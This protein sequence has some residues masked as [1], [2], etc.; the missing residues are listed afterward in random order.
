MQAFLRK[1]AVR[2]AVTLVFVVIAWTM[3]SSFTTLK[4]WQQL[5]ASIPVIIVTQIIWGILHA[6]HKGLDRIMPFSRNTYARIFVQI[7][8]GL[9]LVWVFRSIGLYV[10]PRA[11]H[12][13]LSA[14]ARAT[15]ATITNLVS[16]TVNLALIAEHFTKEWTESRIRQ[17]RLEKEKAQIQ[18]LHLKNQVDPH[19]LFNAFTSLDSLV[20]TQPALASQF[21]R[22]MAKVYRYALEHRDKDVVPL[23]TEL[24]FLE[25][26]IALQQIRFGAAL[27]IDIQV[28]EGAREKG[29]AMVTLQMLL[30]NAVKHNEMHIDMPLRI[31]IYDEGDYLVVTNNKQA[32]KQLA[33]SNQQG[34]QQLKQLY[35]FLSPKLVQVENDPETFTVRLPL[36]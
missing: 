2:I 34:L 29:V 30:D 21:I 20:Q 14:L 7:S 22:H 8:F 28:D 27:E 32:R 31:R 23:Q 5:L 3:R 6:V 10:I 1:Y 11:L 9:L 36:L 24:D 12:M 4:F 26:Y 16:I 35:A 13:E 18:F 17:M 15:V 19:F 33:A 25:H